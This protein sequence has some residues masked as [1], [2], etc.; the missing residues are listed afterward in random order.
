MQYITYIIAWR[1]I[2]RSAR[3]DTLS[4]MVL[5]SFLGIFI[6]SF[7]LTLISAI[8]HGFDIE[9]QKKLQGIH[10]HAI[11]HAQDDSLN[12]EALKLVLNQEFPMIDAFCPTS[13]AHGLLQEDSQ[14]ANN[15]S[16]IIIKA[17]DPLCEPAV[18]TLMQ[19]SMP[20]N[21]IMNM[22]NDGIIIGS[23]L[24]QHHKLNINDMVQIYYAENTN[25]TK[26][27]VTFHAKQAQIVGFIQTGIDDFDSSLV[28]CSFDFF[29]SLFPDIGIQ[30]VHIKF[31]NTTDITKTIMA[32]KK[33]LQLHIYSWQELYP[34]LVSALLLEKY[35][36]CIVLAL[37]TLVA[38]MNIIALIF[39]KITAKR[40]DI[41]ILKALG[42]SNSSVSTIFLLFGA[43]IALT[44]ALCGIT[45]AML[46][47]W[48][49]DHYQLIHLPDAYYV[50]Y[51]PAHISWPI[52][53][54]VFLLV[55]IISFLAAY[56]P[57]RQTRKL[58]IAHTLR[59]EE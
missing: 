43:G 13:Q 16:V 1:Y 18:T 33:R 20:H 55:C 10:A 58:S 21:C 32:L 5:I 24:A 34:A 37:I 50:S 11:M 14:D 31:K 52:P 47:G 35:V 8:M 3:E 6:G 26:N 25:P 36:S 53:V 41:A 46:S 39:M 30:E 38:S 42:L 15:P 9:T 19:N 22:V 27:K 45:L 12:F 56:I 49:I 4:T 29:D 48:L 57:A 40:L 17:I 2:S 23:A 44:A 28:L 51:V 54:G 59:F 7:S